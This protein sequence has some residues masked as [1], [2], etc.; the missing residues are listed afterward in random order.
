MAEFPFQLL[1]N[2]DFSKKQ[3]ESLTCLALLRAVPGKRQVYDAL[4]NNRGVIVKVFLDK[5]SDWR[6][7]KREWRGLKVLQQRGL[8]CPEPLFVGKTQEGRRAI[9]LE[10]I[11]DSPTVLDVFCRAAEPT[12]KLDLLLLVCKEMA[13]QHH[14]GVFQKDLHLGNFL[15]K[16][17]KV[18]AIDP[19]QMCFSSCQLG[20]KKSISQLALLARSVPEDRPE[21]IDRLCQ[22]YALARGWN[23]EKADDALFQKQLVVHE[24]KGIRN[25]LKKSLRTSK[26][27]LRI[28]SGSYVAVFTRDFCQGAEPFDFIEQID[29]LMNNGRILKDGNT[30]YVSCAR[31]N[32]KDVV[33]KRYNNKGLIHS[34]RHTLKR[35]RARRGWL[36]GHRLRLL[37]I[38]TP[39]PFAYLE[40]RRGS[41]I[42]QSYLITEYVQGQNLYNF[43]EDEHVTGQQRL[44]AADEIA[45]LIDKLGKYKIS[46]GDLKHSNILITADGPV[47]TDLDAMKVHKY[48]WLYRIYG[49]KDTARLLSIN[50]SVKCLF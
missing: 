48:R 11:A 31:W 20:R 23:F 26:R 47:L 21:D 17:E 22:E 30:C 16:D 38:A 25:E 1:I 42:W 34:L 8:N 10:K 29:S 12:A 19:S 5:F 39:R 40:Q 35:S 3:V 36:G 50:T 33:I 9:V 6:H 14:K 46:H 28:K 24:K 13:K 49:A 2:R 18:F 45:K 4:W 7:L 41:L 27:Y 15:I 44:R 37:N 43:L 32:N